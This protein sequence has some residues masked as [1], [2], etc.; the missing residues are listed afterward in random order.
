MGITISKNKL[1]IA[2]NVS[3]ILP[4][5]KELDYLRENLAGAKKLEQQ[6]EELVLHMKIKLEGDQFDYQI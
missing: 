1:M 5:H 3:L 2:E 4:F 6:E